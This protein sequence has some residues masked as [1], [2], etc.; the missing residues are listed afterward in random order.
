MDETEV[1]EDTGMNACFRK[2]VYLFSLDAERLL[3]LLQDFAEVRDYDLTEGHL[4]TSFSL[5]VH[6]AQLKNYSK[7]FY[8]RGELEGREDFD[9][10]LCAE[11]HELTEAIQDYGSAEEGVDPIFWSRRR[12]DRKIWTF[13]R[14]T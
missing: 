5:E 10:D 4:H 13:P 11:I 9:K 1:N 7:I 6:T 14:R 2:L 8:A 12:I 3:P